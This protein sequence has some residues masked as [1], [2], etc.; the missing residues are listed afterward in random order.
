MTHLF[1][2]RLKKYIVAIMCEV[3]FRFVDIGGIVDHHCL[4]FLFATWK[5]QEVFIVIKQGSLFCAV[6]SEKSLPHLLNVKNTISLQTFRKKNT[7]RK[8][9]RTNKKNRATKIKTM[10]YLFK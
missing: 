3:I 8:Q 9:N 7:A 4:K 10:H 1:N 2:S 5:L 6:H